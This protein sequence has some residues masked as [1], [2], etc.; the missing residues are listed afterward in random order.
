MSKP[1]AL[2]VARQSSR[3]LQ[4]RRCTA[5]PFSFRKN[6]PRWLGQIPRSRHALPRPNRIRPRR[7]MTSDSMKDR[8]R[9]NYRA[10]T[11]HCNRHGWWTKI[12]A[13]SIR[14]RLAAARATPRQRP[15]VRNFPWESAHRRFRRPQVCPSAG[16]PHGASASRARYARPMSPGCA[17]QIP[18]VASFPSQYI[19]VSRSSRP[20]SRRL[21]QAKQVRARSRQRVRPPR[22]SPT[23]S[24]PES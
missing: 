19:M 14:R 6:A 8:L 13:A 3:S 23:G 24:V 4:A 1:A 18:W 5:C 20:R 10:T 12:C 15:S 22:S 16:A 9:N 21:R 2:A 17:C 11:L 7:K